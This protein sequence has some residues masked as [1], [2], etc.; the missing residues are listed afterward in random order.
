MSLTRKIM[1]AAAPD[2]ERA[3]SLIRRESLTSAVTNCFINAGLNAWMLSGKGPHTLSVDSIAS[4]EATVLGSAVPLAVS[5]SI[6]L[7]TIT[8]FTFRRKA[9]ALDLGPAVRLERRYFFFGFS[10][11][12]ASGFVMFGAVVGASVVWQRLLG[13]VTVSTP[14]AAAIAGIVAAVSAWYA[15]T[16]TATALL[17][18]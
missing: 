12:V 10:N 1:V 8:F 6:I 5:I 14:V 17:R 7:A 4:T 2:A 11:A 15:S 3:Q 13:T 16:R 9:L 18:A